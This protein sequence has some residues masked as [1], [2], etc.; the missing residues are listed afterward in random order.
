MVWAALAPSRAAR[1]SKIDTF[2]AK[3]SHW[4]MA[5]NRQQPDRRKKKAPESSSEDTP[6]GTSIPQEATGGDIFSSLVDFASEPERDEFPAPPAGLPGKAPRLSGKR[7]SDMQKILLIGIVA[8]TA[9]LVYTLAGRARTTSGPKPAKP[10]R[11]R[12]EAHPEHQW[13][14]SPQ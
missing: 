2:A 9:A 1:I 6:R 11:P 8:V 14:A 3:C 13:P 10:P 7:L 5:R 4:T 12:A